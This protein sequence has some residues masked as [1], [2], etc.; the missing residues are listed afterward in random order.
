[1]GVS[2]PL[3]AG[4]HPLGRHPLGRHSTRQTPPSGQI[5]PGQTAPPPRI[6]RDTVNKRA[7]RILVECILVTKYFLVLLAYDFKKYFYYHLMWLFQYTAHFA[8]GCISYIS[9]GLLAG[10]N[11][12]IFVDCQQDSNIPSYCRDKFEGKLG[13]AAASVTLGF[14]LL[15]VNFPLS[16]I[17][18]ILNNNPTKILPQQSG[19]NR[20]HTWQR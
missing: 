12:W 5:P 9:S 14:S 20:V 11:V 2:I 18:C 3:H 10:Y 15:V 7:V 6:L 16:L 13:L 19:G 4:I 17:Y 1:M 8:F